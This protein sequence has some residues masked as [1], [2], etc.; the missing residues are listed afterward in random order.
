MDE[1]EAKAKTDGAAMGGDN[2]QESK[3]TRTRRVIKGS[4]P[5]TITP[6]SI[7]A[8][9][10]RVIDAE[11]PDK[12]SNDFL[13]TKLGSS[14]GAARS[15]PPL[16]K[17]LNLLTG[18]GTPTDLYRKFRSTDSR[19]DAMLSALRHGYSELFKRNEYAHELTDDKLDS[20]IIEITGLP[21]KDSIVSY[22][23]SS[24]KNFKTFIDPSKIGKAQNIDNASIED[25]KISDNPEGKISSQRENSKLGISYNI[26]IVIPETDD[27]NT[28]NAIFQ[29]IKRNLL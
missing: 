15:V 1:V 18:D 4:L 26:N 29:A 13:E 5:Y 19:S 22:I 2:T 12:F 9:L 23:R 28:L 20:L 3:T 14:G 11:T 24:F 10:T 27:I 25:I 17:K 21:K 8:V 6:N 16:L 7:S